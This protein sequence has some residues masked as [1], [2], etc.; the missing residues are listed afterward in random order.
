MSKIE[1]L[2]VI[3]KAKECQTN[4]KKQHKNGISQKWSYYISKSILTPKKDITKINI[5]NASKPTQ[6]PINQNISKTDYLDA[7]ERY[8]KYIEKHYKLP[9]YVTVKKYKIKPYLFTEITSRILLFYNKNNRLPTT[10]EF[11]S[12]IYK[13]DSSAGLH[14]YI[15]SQGCSGMGQCTPYYCACNSLQQCFY[16]LTGIKVDESTI[17]A[18]AGTTTSGTD[19]QGI[20]TAVVWFNKK[21]NKNI[22]ITWKNFNDLGKTDGERWK[23]MQQYIDKGA[24][25]CHI[26]YRDQYGH[27]EVPK[28]V[29][30]DSLTILNS[31][32]DKCTSISYC[33]YIENRTK[34]NQLSYI[35]GISQKSIA[36]LEA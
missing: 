22:K 31:L 35:R 24:V 14:N 23:T 36:I 30:N 16:R 18:I 17:A 34:S 1:Y 28:A 21:Y 27:Y 6:T 26:L 33:G 7:C 29:N 8:T 19:H 12:N 13:K 5:E 11:N 2:S 10:A 32:G 25:F 9:N 3:N 20:N 15:T 4:V